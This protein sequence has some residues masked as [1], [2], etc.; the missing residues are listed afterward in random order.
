MRYVRFARAAFAQPSWVVIKEGDNYTVISRCKCISVV[1]EI[2]RDRAESK[3]LFTAGVR[4]TINN[5]SG[6]NLECVSQTLSEGQ[7]TQTPPQNI[8]AISMA[9][10]GV[11]KCSTA[12]HLGHRVCNLQA[13][14]RKVTGQ[15]AFIIKVLGHEGILKGNFSFG[16]GCAA[17]FDVDNTVKEIE[18]KKQFQVKQTTLICTIS[19]SDRPY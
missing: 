4:L 17:S 12:I 8:G 5:N 7:W 3:C 18:V 14:G 16:P 11:S 9:V 1:P 10:G 19:I 13:S 15:P 6:S 2:V